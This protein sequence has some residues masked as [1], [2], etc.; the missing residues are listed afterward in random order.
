MTAVAYLE[1]LNAEQRRAVEHW[2]H[3]G[4]SASVG[5]PLLIIAGAGSGNARV[6]RRQ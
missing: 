5:G 6:R 1:K 4:L 3:D 2:L